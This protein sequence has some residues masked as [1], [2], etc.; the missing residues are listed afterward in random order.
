MQSVGCHFEKRSNFSFSQ[1]ASGA[2]GLLAA[3]RRCECE[4]RMDAAAWRRGGGAAPGALPIF[5]AVRVGDE[6]PAGQKDPV[7]KWLDFKPLIVFT[8][9]LNVDPCPPGA[10]YLPSPPPFLTRPTG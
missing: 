6:T 2:D 10:T 4:Q 1:L 7:L 9:I 8:A 3:E 5:P